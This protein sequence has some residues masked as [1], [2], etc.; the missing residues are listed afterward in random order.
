MDAMAVLKTLRKHHCS[1]GKTHY[2]VSKVDLIAMQ[3]GY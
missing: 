1:E 3:F 2:N